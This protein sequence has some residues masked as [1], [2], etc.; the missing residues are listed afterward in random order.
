MHGVQYRAERTQ[1]VAEC[2]ACGCGD[3]LTTAH[4]DNGSCIVGQVRITDWYRARGEHFHQH[5]CTV[6]ELQLD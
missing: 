2:L 1:Y 3:S 6:C 4:R 5:A